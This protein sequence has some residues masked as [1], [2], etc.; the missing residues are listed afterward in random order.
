MTPNRDQQNLTAAL[1][2]ARQDGYLRLSELGFRAL[3]PEVL[4]LRGIRS[5]TLSSLTNLESAQGIEQLS[6]LESVDLRG[7]PTA[8]LDD[9][10]ARLVKLPRL[11]Q[12]RVDADTAAQ[13]PAALDRM[14]RLRE[15]EVRG[16]ASTPLASLCTRLG[17]LAGLRVLRLRGD[18][19]T[20]P[21]ALPD[22]IAKISQ[23]QEL[24]IA[25]PCPVLNPALTR[26]SALETLEVNPPT[27]KRHRIQVIPEAIGELSLLRT[28]HLRGHNIHTIPDSL[29]DLSELRS[30][31]L[32][33]SPIE[34][35]PACFSNLSNLA[36]LDLSY[37][38]KLKLLPSDIGKLRALR[39]LA[40][41]DTA[42]T[43]LPP[44]FAELRLTHVALPHELERTVALAPPDVARVDDLTIHR[45]H[46]SALPEDLGDPLKLTIQAP[47]L[48]AP[49]VAFD[50]LRRLE[51]LSI[52]SA[53]KFDLGD[54]LLRLLSAQKLVRLHLDDWTSLATLPAAIAG[55]VHLEA[56]SLRGARLTTLPPEIGALSALR[57]LDLSGNP[58]RMIPEACRQMTCLEEVSICNVV[59][60][61]DGL[62]HFASLKR[63][64][65]SNQTAKALPVELGELVHLEELSLASCETTDLSVLG[66]LPSLRSLQM[67]WHRGEFNPA[68]LCRA[69]ARTKIQ[70]LSFHHARQL[71]EL[72][73]QLGSLVTLR[74]IDVR[75]TGVREFPTETAQLLN[76]QFIQVQ[77]FSIRPA[78][79]TKV[80]PKG[81]WR[82]EGS[83]ERSCAYRRVG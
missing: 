2:R 71:K 18:R 78:D 29:C 34:R 25:A 76:L 13:F 14:Q 43:S 44:S 12:L 20:G 59:P 55:L 68:E 81:R 39:S 46:D 80:L 63:L 33:G 82:K 36:S 9:L 10:F 62:R 38:H 49:A 66:A 77:D 74:S 45:L 41:A 23:L 52:M 47:A 67:D 16:A 17:S 48:E 27:L 69:L 57:R 51:Y 32:F 28:L 73:P 24:L 53:P 60:L 54:A 65:L 8:T 58:L 31:D 6:D 50:R 11:T 30:L 79:L 70:S 56:L 22:S 61:P 7:I 1:E 4:A 37:C 40:A 15:L 42:I 64:S 75:S 5:V 3:P 35:L 19:S 72:P 21:I 26:L 83:G